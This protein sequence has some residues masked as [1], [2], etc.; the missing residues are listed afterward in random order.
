MMRCSKRFVFYLILMTGAL[1][2]SCQ[3]KDT[4]TGIFSN[5][6]QKEFQLE[7]P[8]GE[9]YFILLSRLSCSGCVLEAQH[10]LL[11]YLIQ[12][13]HLVPQFTFIYSDKENANPILVQKL[14]SY[15]DSF[16]ALEQLPA[17]TDNMIIVKTASNNVKE[18]IFI[19]SENVSTFIQN[20]L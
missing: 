7:I 2:L 12:N 3:E 8:E 9:H 14:F 17:L 10:V 1:F 15:Y 16:S 4:K 18:W 5:Y 6:L 20:I 19:N 11:N 13:P